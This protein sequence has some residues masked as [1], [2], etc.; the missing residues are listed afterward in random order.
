VPFKH[1]DRNANWT[2]NTVYT[3]HF[4]VDVF[5][6]LISRYGQREQQWCFGQRRHFRPVY[7]FPNGGEHNL[8]VCSGQI[9]FTLSA[10]EW[11]NDNFQS[12]AAN[13]DG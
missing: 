12:T 13:Y 8:C 5:L 4:L 6:R 10:Q 1:S 11:F 7:A 9:P 3:R 2:T